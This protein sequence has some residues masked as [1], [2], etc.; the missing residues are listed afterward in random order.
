[1]FKNYENG[2]LLRKQPFE[3]CQLK[4]MAKDGALRLDGKSLP[5]KWKEHTLTDARA[6]NRGRMGRRGLRAT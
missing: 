2:W 3:N 1:M 4:L 5:R 6:P